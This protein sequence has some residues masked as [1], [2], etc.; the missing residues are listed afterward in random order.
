MESQDCQSPETLKAYALGR[1]PDEEAEALAD[2]LADCPVCEETLAGF[3]DTADSFVGAVRDAGDGTED[4]AA[5]SDRLDTAL[6]QIANPYDHDSKPTSPVAECIR[7][8]ELLEPLGR[9]GMGTVYRALHRSLDRI[10]AVKLLPGRRLRAPQAVERFRREMKAIGRLNHP[11]IVR[12][13]DAGEVDGTH[14]LAMDYVDGIDLSRLVKYIGPLPVADACEII[15]Q[16]ALALQYAHEQGLIHRDVKPGNLMLEAGAPS[17]GQSPAVTVKVMDLGLA[18][19]GAASEA[20]DELTTVGQLMGT[21]DYMAPEQAD[22]SHTVD[23]TADVYSLGA[24]L[25]KLLTGQAP[26][27]T[28]E[29]RTPL[30]KMKAL[31]LVDA[32]SIAGYRSDLPAGLADIIDRMLLRDASQRPRTA[33]DVAES[34]E[35]FCSGHQLDDLL[36]RGIREGEA[37]HVSSRE[38]EAPAEPLGALLQGSAQR[39]LRPPTPQPAVSGRQGGG[40]RRVITVCAGLAGII[41][42]AGVIWLQTDKGML[43]IESA[44]DQV[45]VEIRQGSDVVESLTLVAGTNQVQLRSGHYE[46]VLPLEYDNLKVQNGSVEIQRGANWIARVSETAE[47]PGGRHKTVVEPRGLT[48]GGRSFDE[49]NLIVRNER[50]P[51]DLTTAIRALC[52]LGRE[53]RDEE[54]ADAVFSVVRRMDTKLHL[55]EPLRGVSLEAKAETKLLLTA[56]DQ[57]RQLAADA[58]L[59][60]AIRELKLKERDSEYLIATFLA[61]QREWVA[62]AYGYT[63]GEKELTVRDGR[64]LAGTFWSSPDYVAL[65]ER[66]FKGLSK[67]QRINYLQWLTAD[68]WSEPKGRELSAQQEQIAIDSLRQDADVRVQEVAAELLA[69]RESDHGVPKVLLELIK[70]EPNVKRPD[71]SQQSGFSQWFMNSPSSWEKSRWVIL[72]AATQQ[73]RSEPNGQSLSILGQWT[74]L[75]EPVYSQLV[76]T[77]S[78]DRFRSGPGASFSTSAGLY[79]SRR[80]LAAET[81]AE[82][83]SAAASELPA[84]NARIEKLCGHPPVD[85]GRIGVTTVRTQSVIPTLANV[86]RHQSDEAGFAS[87]APDI[88]EFESMVYAVQK[89]TGHAVRFD[90]MPAFLLKAGKGPN[91]PSVPLF[92][93][94]DVNGWT[95]ER[96]SEMLA[97]DEPIDAET[98]VDMA[99]AIYLFTAQ[100]HSQLEN[101]EARLNV[102]IVGGDSPAEMQELIDLR[103]ELFRRMTQ[104]PPDDFTQYRDNVFWHPDISRLVSVALP[105]QEGENPGQSANEPAQVVQLLRRTPDPAWL[106]RIIDR[107]VMTDAPIFTPGTDSSSSQPLGVRTRAVQLGRDSD[108]GVTALTAVLDSMYARFDDYPEELQ[109]ALL[110]CLDYQGWLKPEHASFLMQLLESDNEYHWIRAGETARP[111]KTVGEAVHKRAKERLLEIVL[112]SKSDLNATNAGLLLCSTYRSDWTDDDTLK[113]IDRLVKNDFGNDG[114]HRIGRIPRHGTYS[115]GPIRPSVVLVDAENRLVCRRSLLINILMQRIPSR[116]ET[117]GDANHPIARMTSQR[118]LH[119][120]RQ[121]ELRDYYLNRELY[122]ERDSFIGAA[123][124]DEAAR[125]EAFFKE[126][127]NDWASG[128]ERLKEPG[129]PASSLSEDE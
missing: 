115:E 18:L 34:L 41:A 116:A 101:D 117:F 32:P 73:V 60:N 71:E 33:Q 35:P 119:A 20:I 55:E 118:S 85:N 80:T 129:Q 82:I 51:E 42:L 1:L 126:L 47:V 109:T 79:I 61:P 14:Y 89:I 91:Q 22:S 113:V 110:N 107:F 23:A 68:A 72:R 54:T 108:E 76:V 40:F 38:G 43:K 122:V 26:Y 106:Q 78:A 75:Q 74:Q 64:P 4:A 44:G 105:P 84:I 86:R 39:E 11:S 88:N 97:G 94:T 98:F 127:L 100:L 69:P 121:R 8:Y 15:R 2:H 31:S 120:I 37:R 46:I 21:L 53:S 95:P 70:A 102:K 103:W 50:S 28:D 66:E 48:F 49:W 16:A 77:K 27:E 81:L 124:D 114:P 65:I 59:R 12:A 99:K 30:K 104:M 10:V 56:I 17:H 63:Y 24:T 5:A 112:H 90:E 52:T 58:V 123:T 111:I 62:N 93:M 25:F 83:G 128:D 9:G 125:F 45:P 13:T 67:E 96:M 87:M 19:F 6:R 57:L 36:T 29:Y 7:D 92:R 3:D